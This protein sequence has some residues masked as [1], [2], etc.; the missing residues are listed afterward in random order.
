MKGRDNSKKREDGMRFVTN[1]LGILCRG[2]GRGYGARNGQVTSVRPHMIEFEYHSTPP[3]VTKDT[4]G[5]G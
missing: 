3:L 4:K 1:D 2:L 5:L